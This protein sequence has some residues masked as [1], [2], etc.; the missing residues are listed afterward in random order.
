MM[1]E[2]DKRFKDIDEKIVKLSQDS[3][4]ELE[5]EKQARIER[6]AEKVDVMKGGISAGFEFAAAIV[7]CM[8]IGIWMDRQFDMAP[9]WM[10][11]WM[12]MGIA[13]AFYNLYRASQ[14]L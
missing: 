11:I 2:E 5:H 7:I 12:F 6:E 9:L 13:V 4:I 14:K 10:L 1:D 3:G 8:L